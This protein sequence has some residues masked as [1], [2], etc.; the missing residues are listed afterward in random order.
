MTAFE[1]LMK[2][3]WQPAVRTAPAYH[4]EPT[5]INGLATSIE[6]HLQGLDWTPDLLITS[7]HGLPE[8]YFRNGDPYH[9]HCF[10]TTRLVREKLGWSDDRMMVAFQSRFGRSSETLPSGH[11]EALPLKA[12]RHYMPVFP[13]RLCQTLEE[14]NIGIRETFLKGRREFH[15]SHAERYRRR[16]ENN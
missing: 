3:R 1:A 8:R 9:C 4:D 15:P 6:T 5:Y 2:L 14:I 10:K 13:F 12:S 7:Y 16:H 11:V